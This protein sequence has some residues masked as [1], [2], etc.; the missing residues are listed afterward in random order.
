MF[1][2]VSFVDVED[3]PTKTCR[4]ATLALV[5]KLNVLLILKYSLVAPVPATLVVSKE[6]AENTEPIAVATG[7]IILVLVVQ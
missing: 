2:A 6:D 4:F 7:L 1:V 3:L 5:A